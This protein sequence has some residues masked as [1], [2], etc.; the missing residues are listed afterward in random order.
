MSAES[1]APQA[2]LVINVSRI[3]DTLLVTPAIRALARKWPHARITFLGHPQRV[4]IMRNLPT[5][6]AA[7]PITKRTAVLRGWLGRREYD[8]ALVYGNDP[9]LIAY[10]LR[11][12]H[13]VVAFRQNDAKLDA[14][15][16]RC[17][18]P[19]AFQAAHSALLPLL[20][21]RALGVEDAGGALDYRVT[22]AEGQWSRTTLAASMDRTATPRIGLQVASFPTKAYRDWPIGHFED[23]CDR[24]LARWPGTHFLI[25][26]GSL[27]RER[28]EALAKRYPGHATLY[29]G[30]LSL[31]ESAALMNTLDLYIGVDTGPTHIM[32][33]LHRPMIA[34]YHCYSP[35]RLLAPLEHPCCTAIDHPRTGGDCGPET[36]MA[37]ITVD[38]V[39]SAVVAMLEARPPQTRDDPAA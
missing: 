21:P 28:T 6:A 22:A 33:A 14:R 37:E 30:R 8:L 25:F 31:R 23:L 17:V 13:R 19:P 29:A 1:A 3:G 36:P 34:L 2:I 32:G 10:A 20:L 5:L 39:W 4:E 35:S 15:L 26:G 24:I 7:E 16:Y 18:E 9:T 11:V 27:E 12:A 38:T